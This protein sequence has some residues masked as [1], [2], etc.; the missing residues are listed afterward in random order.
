MHA[1]KCPDQP[2]CREYDEHQGDYA[3]ETCAAVA[4]VAIVA[5]PAAEQQDQQDD[6]LK[7]YIRQSHLIVS[8]ALT[9]KK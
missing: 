8:G 4:A 1:A 5:T 7:D 9:K 6:A 2:Q 3:T